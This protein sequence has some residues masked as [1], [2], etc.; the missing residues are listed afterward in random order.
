MARERLARFVPAFARPVRFPRST[1]SFIVLFRMGVPKWDRVE[2]S[3]SLKGDIGAGLLSGVPKCRRRAQ[4]L[5]WQI[6]QNSGRRG[7]S[8]DYE[9]VIAAA[10]AE[11]L[12]L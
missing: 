7:S 12:A 1:G 4:I 5:A 8:I 2:N 9:R 3:I 10:P 6:R 11:S